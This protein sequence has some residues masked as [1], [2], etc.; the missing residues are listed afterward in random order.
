MTTSLRVL[1][2]VTVF[3]L[4]SVAR[5]AALG[6]RYEQVLRDHG[7]PVGQVVMGNRRVLSYPKLSVRLKDDVW[8]WR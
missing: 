8:W 5:A 2:A 6:D 1:F 3:L 4:G 7:N